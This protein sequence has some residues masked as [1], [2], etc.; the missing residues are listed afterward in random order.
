MSPLAHSSPQVNP[1]PEGPAGK[2]L[3]A[4]GYLGWG[5]LSLV[6]LI[7]QKDQ[8][9]A[10]FHG[11][12]ALVILILMVAAGM[13]RLIPIIGELMWITAVVVLGLLSLWGLVQALMGQWWKIPWISSIAEKIS[14]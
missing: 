2:I 5:I 3:A 9:F 13:T 6:P 1:V 10:V 7:L 8:P 12:Q 14:L 4:V 11:K